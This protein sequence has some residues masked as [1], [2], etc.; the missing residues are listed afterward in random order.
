MAKETYPMTP[1]M[2]KET[3]IVK[4]LQ[5]KQELLARFV[6][7]KYDKVTKIWTLPDGDLKG[8]ETFELH[9]DSD[10]NW[11][12][13]VWEK[14]RDLKLITFNSALKT[15]HAYVEHCGKIRERLTD[16]T[17]LEAFEALCSAIIWL[18]ELKK[19]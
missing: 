1:K 18:E 6:D 3:P 16:G 7:F 15:D 11:L 17:H 10:R 2:K 9:F 5:E 12:H 13:R 19:K 8:G 4:D 14:F